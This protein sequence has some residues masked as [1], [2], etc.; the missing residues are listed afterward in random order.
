MWDGQMW[1]NTSKTQRTWTKEH[2]F[3]LK[4]SMKEHW[5]LTWAERNFLIFWEKIKTWAKQNGFRR[6]TK[7]SVLNTWRKWGRNIK[8]QQNSFTKNFMRWVSFNG[9]LR[10]GNKKDLKSQKMTPLQNRVGKGWRENFLPS[11]PNALLNTI[12]GKARM[13]KKQRNQN[14]QIFPPLRRK[15]SDLEITTPKKHNCRWSE[16]QAS[17]MSQ[18]SLGQQQPGWSL[19]WLG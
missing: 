13:P 10:S 15:S 7:Q 9:K 2:A 17:S 14:Q 5:F 16:D 18:R 1:N 11:S 3:E 8:N 6:K 12:H 19:G 4:P